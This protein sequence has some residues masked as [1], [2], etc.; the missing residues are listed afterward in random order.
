MQGVLCPPKMNVLPFQ[1]IALNQS[2]LPFLPYKNER[3]GNDVA[4]SVITPELTLYVQI[5]G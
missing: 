2:D 1:G 4:I 5:A 3:R